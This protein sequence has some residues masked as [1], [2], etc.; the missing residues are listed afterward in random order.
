MNTSTISARLDEQLRRASSRITQEIARRAGNH[1]EM[2]LGSGYPKSGT[3]W[4]CQ[5]M[6]SYLDVPH[7]QNYSLPVAMSAV[8]HNHWLHD[9]SFPRSAYIRRDGRDVMVS[10]YFYQM[11]SITQARHPHQAARLDER[12]TRLFGAGYDPRDIRSNLPTFIAAEST[13]PFAFRQATWS[14]HLRSWCNP[15]HPNVVVTTYESLLAHPV[16][17]FTKVLEFLT[18]GTV[19][20]RR[21]QLSL[22]RFSFD[23]SGRKPG[24]EDLNEF[25]RKG[26][27]GDWKEHFSREAGA[28][29]QHHQ[30]DALLEYGYETDADWYSSLPS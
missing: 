6:S 22:E 25:M 12:F 11:R 1:Y 5:V 26:V 15:A 29:F 21:L 8:L 27:A 24:E 2:Y 17:N 7:P 20:A 10:L 3:S 28:A 19:D 16:S 4:L 13:Q 30:G 9:P 23:R 14:Q 18:Q